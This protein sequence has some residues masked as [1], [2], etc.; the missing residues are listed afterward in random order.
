M[1]QLGFQCAHI[2]ASYKRTLDQLV[3]LCAL[4]SAGQSSNPLG[5]GFVGRRRR[6]LSACW[7]KKSLVCPT[8]KHRCKASPVSRELRCR[9]VSVGQRFGGFLDLCG[10]IFFLSIIPRDCHTPASRFFFNIIA[11]PQLA[12]FHLGLHVPKAHTSPANVGQHLVVV[13]RGTPVHARAHIAREGAH[14]AC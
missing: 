4:H 13:R 8:S 6:S 11:S 5:D 14:I 10:K 2:I 3:W 12:A 7:K 9:C 1:S